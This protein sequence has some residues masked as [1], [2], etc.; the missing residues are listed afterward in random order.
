[1][2]LCAQD[3]PDPQEVFIWVRKKHLMMHWAVSSP[4]LASPFSV[5]LEYSSV[6]ALVNCF[7]I[8]SCT[9]TS[10]QPDPRCFEISKNIWLNSDPHPLRVQTA[11][12]NR[13]RVLGNTVIDPPDQQVIVGRN[14]LLLPSLYDSPLLST[15]LYLPV[16]IF[17]FP[18]NCPSKLRFFHQHSLFLFILQTCAGMK[19]VLN[20]LG[21]YS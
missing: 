15:E 11:V 3:R 20:V 16:K 2:L 14:S 7:L 12:L 13:W 10:T 8:I 4:T 6:S 17:F 1:M 21:K 5:L 9:C 18:I 19:L